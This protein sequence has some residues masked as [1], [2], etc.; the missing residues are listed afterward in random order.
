MSKLSNTKVLVTGIGAAVP[1]LATLPYDTIANCAA[2]EVTVLDQSMTPV[3]DN[4]ATGTAV[5]AVTAP[6]LYI[7]VKR[8][9]GTN[10]IWSQK[11]QGRQ[12][13]KF[14]TEEGT[15]A[16]EQISFI[17]DNGATGDLSPVIDDSDYTISIIFTNDKVQGSERQLVRRM[18][19]TSDATATA[20]EIQTALIAA[21]NA[22]PVASKFVVA[23][24]STGGGN[25]G[26]SITGLAISSKTAG[27]YSK[28]VGYEQ[29]QF[30]VAAG[31]A[32]TTATQID[33][34]GFIGSAAGASTA[35]Y[36]GRNTSELVS[37]AEYAAVYAEGISNFTKFPTPTYA[38]TSDTITTTR[39]YSSL[40]L[41]FGDKHSSSNLNMD[42]TSPERVV[43][44][45]DTTFGV[46]AAA[47]RL[48]V[49]LD[50]YTASVGVAHEGTALS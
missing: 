22:D 43:I 14:C 10:A 13:T 21:I 5:T 2:G 45:T 47:R 20:L 8:P 32:F 3:D 37:D 28:L 23:A 30:Q 26:I 24:A 35:P 11:I 25:N 50:T 33:E 9:D 29:V 41:E 7:V 49:T 46:T 12:I 6:E 17:G 15:A 40:T 31:G 44:Y 42:L 18:T 1:T 39:N 16:I 27:T 48:Q 38:I 4:L 36:A 34:N 19:I